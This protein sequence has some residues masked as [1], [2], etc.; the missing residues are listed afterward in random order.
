MMMIDD[1]DDD[2]DD[3][4][5]DNDDDNDDEEDED[6]DEEHEDD[7]ENDDDHHHD[8][9]DRM[10][11]SATDQTCPNDRTVAASSLWF[12]T[13]RSA[14]CRRT[15]ATSRQNGHDAWIKHVH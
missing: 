5:D 12:S 15:M 14:V 6:A 4:N 7:E 8:D 1:D 9:H 10:K 2:D 3:R 13:T 11:V